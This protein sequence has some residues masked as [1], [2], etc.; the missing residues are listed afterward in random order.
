[1][2]TGAVD[3]GSAL[4]FGSLIPL[5]LSKPYG[6]LLPCIYGIGTGIPVLI[7]SLAMA[8][9]VSTLLHWLHKVKAPEKYTRKVTGAIFI[10][11]GLYFIYKEVAG[12]F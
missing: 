9:G 4:F 3:K 11:A 5:S 6:V 2:A 10:L 8:F 7:F 1:M 12:F